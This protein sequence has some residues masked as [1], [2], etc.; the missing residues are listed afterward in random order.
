MAGNSRVH[1]RPDLNPSQRGPRLKGPERDGAGTLMGRAPW[2]EQ[3]RALTVPLNY[4]AV[5]V[6]DFVNLR[7]FPFFP[8]LFPFQLK[9]FRWANDG[10]PKM[11]RLSRTWLKN[12][13]RT[14]LPKNWTAP[15]A[16][17]SSKLSSSGSP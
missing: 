8:V 9:E 1:G 6:L 13:Q 5:V 12:I 14:L 4:Q 3:T 10:L 11:S 15:L 2:D 17:L 7:N 16:V